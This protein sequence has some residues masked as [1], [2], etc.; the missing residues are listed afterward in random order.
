MKILLCCADWGIPL[1]GNAGS[2]VHLRSLATALAGLGHEVR[3]V[4]SNAD[5]T[6]TPPLPVEVVAVE[7]IWPAVQALV[8]RLRGQRRT[9]AVA[10][11]ASPAP[12][13]AV[14][15]PQ[16]GER[17]AAGESAVGASWKTRL[18]YDTLPRLADRTQECL[19]H[20]LRFGRTISRIMAEFR[21][22]AVY[23][24]YALCQTGA[25]RAVRTAGGSRV[26]YLLEVNASLAGERFGPGK[27]ATV[28]G[29]WSA[30]EEGRLWR[31]A[32][33]VLC[34]SEQLRRLAIAVGA[35]PSRVL[36]MPNGVDVEAFRPDRPKGE[37]RRRIGVGEDTILI[38][39]LGSLSPGRGAEAFLHALAQ[40]LRLVPEAV[41][42][43]IGSGPL[44]A[45]CRGLAA[46][47]G[48]ARR[49][50]FVGAVDHERTPDLL[51]DLDIAV[52]CYPRRKDFYFSPMKVAEYLACGLPVVCGRTGG[53]AEMVAD[54]INGL[55]VEPDDAGAWGLALARLCRDRGLRA[56]LGLQARRSAL[57]GPTWTG[58]ARLVEREIM[59]CRE[60][61]AR[62][63][64]TR[65]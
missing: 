56:H 35:E 6:S 33:R 53:P 19:F 48:I 15:R 24:R 50:V 10:A 26:P 25:A 62:Q 5:G 59:R 13:S 54:G 44:D 65:P 12:A 2:S 31:G 49:V 57:A 18:Y 1:G 63:R 41:G 14:L 60:S 27:S 29:W 39:W 3:L 30:R 32:D 46:Q 64:R 9:A 8:E 58:N 20:P 11:S 28:L 51:V 45:T 47:L 40:A 16:G 17:D 38:G 42:V 7:R 22:D 43:V 23:E 34:V 21:P 36:V 55:L 61:L 4:V 52:A 37:L